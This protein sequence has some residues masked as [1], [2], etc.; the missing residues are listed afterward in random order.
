MI[1]KILAFIVLLSVLTTGV[2]PGSF[3]TTKVN[4]SSYLPG[5]APTQD[6][7]DIVSG[8]PLS[9]QNISLC[10]YGN[11][12][13]SQ[14]K[15]FGN[16]YVLFMDK[17]PEGSTNLKVSS[18][19]E[20]ILSV[21]KVDDYTRAISVTVIKPGKITLKVTGNNKGKSVSQQAVIK[22]I[23]YKNAAK[24]LLLN[25]KNYTSK[26]NATSGIYQIKTKAGHY[27]IKCIPKAGWRIKNIIPSSN[28]GV[29]SVKVG[30]IKNNSY[31]RL[32]EKQTIYI[33][34]ELYN[35]KAGI[36]RVM[37]LELTAK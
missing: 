26:F 25:N 24:S 34:I 4:A 29:T 30:K 35:K 7:A 13:S 21:K 17:I 33:S 11:S 5:V 37:I 23:K 10:C 32:K 15:A 20:K 1:K 9:R 36:N 18:T 19:N 8:V 14:M 12:D 16:T 28:R 31:I 3:M 22:I 27:K 6:M 2:F